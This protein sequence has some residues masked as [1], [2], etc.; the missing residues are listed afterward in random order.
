MYS[1]CKKLKQLRGAL[2]DINKK[3]Y[4][5]IS[6]QVQRA[7]FALEEA[8]RNLQIS[9]LN[10]E[11]IK[12]RDCE[13][14][15]F[16]QKARI[17]WIVQGDRC[18]NFFHSRIKSNR[19]HNKVLVLYNNLGQRLS[20][21]EEIANE[22]TSFERKIKSAILSIDDNKAPGSDGY[23]VAFYKSAWPV[24][25]EEVSSPILDFFKDGKMLGMV[26]S[27]S[28][29]LI[30]KVLANRIK[31]II[32][33]I[34][35]EAQSAFVKGRQITSNISLAHELAKNYTRKNISPRILMNI[36][37]RKAFDTIN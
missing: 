28:I 4:Y 15:F 12:L 5:N 37:I 26:N 14:S 1:I 13:L 29:T 2:K 16:Q 3:H 8:Q 20:D 18:T 32:G 33:Y 24:V 25:R 17:K 7:K 27:T 10:P 11:F 9:P 6:E 30:P 35:N 31:P 36:D 23:R 19:H 22:L 34:V 21:Q